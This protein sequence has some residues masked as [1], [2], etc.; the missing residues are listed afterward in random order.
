MD[1]KKVNC[2]WIN[3]RKDGMSKRITTIPVVCLLALTIISG[4]QA[5]DFS[6]P[7]VE[8]GTEAGPYL[9]ETPVPECVS[10]P[11]ISLE[12]IL[13][14]ENSAQVRITG[15]Q[16]NEPVYTIFR[17]QTDDGAKSTECCPGETASEKGI[18]EY[19]VG[20]RGAEVDREFTDCQVRVIHSRGAACAEFTLPDR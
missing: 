6:T 14:S 5:G 9:N 10:L 17:S 7:R 16:A 15:L 19:S 3:R 11:G 20:L 18:Y 13:L 2:L 4:C 12:V 8:I 1:I